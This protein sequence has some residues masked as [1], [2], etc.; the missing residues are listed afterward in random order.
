[1]GDE[2]VYLIEDDLLE[3][4][5][6]DRDDF[7][8]HDEVSDF[9]T[10]AELTIAGETALDIV[11]EPDSSYSYTDSYHYYAIKDGSH[12]ALSDTLVKSWLNTLTSLDLTDY[13]TYTASDEDLSEY[14]L[15][16][17]AYTISVNGTIEAQSDEE[18]AE[19]VEFV[20]YIGTIPDDTAEEEADVIAYARLGESEIVYRLS[21]AE[22]E[23]LSEC[24]YNSLRPTQVLSLDWDIVTEVCIGMNGESYDVDVMTRADWEET[25]NAGESDGDEEADGDEP[26][27]VLNGSEID[28]EAVMTAADAMEID[29]FAED[30]ADKTQELSMTVS[31]D[32]DDY[33]SVTVEIYQYDGESCLV[34]VDGETVGLMQRS[35]MVDLREAMTA[36]V[37]E[38]E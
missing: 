17:P 9:D 23:I 31:L 38:M 12:L 3:Y 32:R 26:V 36:I 2:K 18:S 14:G 22:Y 27:Y 25:G 29:T 35:M 34:L 13:A 1:M 10:L 24:S 28:F 6:T 7:M 16:A 37:L 21:S 15:D 20:L 11:Y 5:T 8:Q 33:S 30:A 4:V 19:D